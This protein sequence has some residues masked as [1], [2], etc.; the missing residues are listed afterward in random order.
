MKYFKIIE[1]KEIIG[2]VNSNN[3]FI[4]DSNWLL[5]SND[6]LGQYVEYNGILYRDYWMAPTV[7]N[8][9]FHQVLISEISQKDYFTYI[10]AKKDNETIILEEEPEIVEEVIEEPT[11]QEPDIFL[12]TVREMKI[13]QISKACRKTI[14]EGFD[15]EMRG[16]TKHFSLSTQDQLNL[17]SLAQ[18]AQTQSMLPY[19]ADG[20]EVVFYAAEEIQELV[21]E[22]NAFKI[23][24]TTYYNALKAYIKSL[25][26]VEEISAVEYGMEIPEEYK[27]DV[28]KALE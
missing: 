12:E 15:M 13:S 4:D 6:I 18:M 9:I 11:Q 14:E 3:F 20:E 28:L 21:D 2:V 22:M 27:T 24:H 8:R 5:T 16:E 1:N 23:Y 26:T 10:K 17:M 25:L 7:S 19:H